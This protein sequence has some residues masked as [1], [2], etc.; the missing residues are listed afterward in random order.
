MEVAT[1]T[2]PEG[3][4]NAPFSLATYDLASRVRTAACAELQAVVGSVTRQVWLGPMNGTATQTSRRLEDVFLR[5]PVGF[6]S[7]SIYLSLFHPI[8]LE[9]V[10]T[11]ARV[12]TKRRSISAICMCMQFVDLCGNFQMGLV[13]CDRRRYSR[14][15]TVQN[16]TMRREV[17]RGGGA[18]ANSLVCLDLS[19]MVSFWLLGE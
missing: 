6:F 7:A 5:Y 8:L 10:P 18:R 16:R 9:D 11:H 3:F 13:S 14:E 17:G 12:I 4:T 1:G 15:R 19:N 2:N